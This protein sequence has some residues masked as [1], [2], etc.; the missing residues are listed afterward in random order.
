LSIYIFYVLLYPQKGIIIFFAV[1][2][3]F[4]RILAG[5]YE[6]VLC[7]AQL[8]L[9]HEGPHGSLSTERECTSLVEDTVTTTEHDH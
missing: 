7:I 3:Y 9:Q 6:N 1:T 5:E 2:Q 4:N 8:Y